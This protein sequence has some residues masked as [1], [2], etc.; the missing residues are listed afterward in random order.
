MVK[1]I[2]RSIRPLPPHKETVIILQPYP[3]P[4][5]SMHG[6]DVINVSYQ[7]AALLKIP[8]SHDGCISHKEVQS[9]T[10]LNLIDRDN[11]SFSV[12][13]GSGRIL[14]GVQDHDLCAECDMDST[15]CYICAVGICL[16]LRRLTEPNPCQK[17]YYL[18]LIRAFSP[19]F[20]YA[21]Q[22]PRQES[23]WPCTRS[24]MS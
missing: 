1:K 23:R 10:N 20:G 18:M 5:L 24:Q 12:Q 6:Q 3:G 19:S 14:L 17:R 9:F 22:S 2:P 7:L 15:R 4:L 16:L 13:G 11:C 21:F 8:F